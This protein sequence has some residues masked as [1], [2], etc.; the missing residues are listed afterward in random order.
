MIKLTQLIL[1]EQAVDLFK[2]PKKAA[3]AVCPLYDLL[4]WQVEKFDHPRPRS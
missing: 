3:K 1:T 2:G 4:Y